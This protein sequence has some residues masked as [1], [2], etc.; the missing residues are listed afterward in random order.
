MDDQW[1]RIRSA[2]FAIR[3]HPKCM[4]VLCT[5]ALSGCSLALTKAPSSGDSPGELNCTESRAV[6]LID[7]GL[8]LA[9]AATSRVKTVSPLTGEE[10]IL[11]GSTVL[12]AAAVASV[13]AY[14]AFVGWNRVSDCRAAKE[15]AAGVENAEGGVEE[16]PSRPIVFTADRDGKEELYLMDADGG[17]PRRLTF[18]P[19][20]GAFRTPRYT[21]SSY[22]AWS[23]DGELIA[24]ASRRLEDDAPEANARSADIYLMAP[25]G[26]GL[27][28][29]T[30][31][32]A[33]DLG[34]DFAPDGQVL[35]FTS[36]RDGNY[37]IYAIRIDGAHLTRLTDNPGRDS[38]PDW[39][40]S[41]RSILFES[42]GREG[43]RG[44]FVMS[45]DG[46]GVRHLVV[47]RHGAWSPDGS[48]IAFGAQACWLMD[49]HERVDP[50]PLAWAEVQ[51]RCESSGDQEIALFTL[52]LATGRIDRVFPRA[53]PGVE[54]ASADGA[55]TAFVSGG[56]DP[57]WSP[58]GT[59]LV[60]HYSRR[61][62]D[63]AHIDQCCKDMEIF[64]V[65][66]D[67]TGLTALTWNVDFDG[68]PKWH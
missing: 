1:K 54:V 25:D 58:D 66:L 43:R 61:G 19:G 59:Q 36:D 63:T 23:P 68:Y 7:I 47:G 33:S 11:V 17:N 12:L 64:K 20:D 37:E 31:N 60:F 48:R 8:A 51:S 4:L 13:F 52:E 62:D 67:G 32:A 24:F 41:G 27:R 38:G 15:E 65:N 57:Q 6:P 26:S 56:S 14:S 18:T 16:G 50:E 29:I 3:R 45:P 28:R 30:T 39:H 40:P 5:L 42:R 53:A 49:S 21:N 44:L 35:A 22:G 10:E 55:K 2:S 9:G 34:P 46:T